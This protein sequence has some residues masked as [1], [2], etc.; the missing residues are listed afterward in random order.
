MA[1]RANWWRAAAAVFTVINVGGAIFAVMR[2][3]MMHA[4]THAALLVGTIVAWQ[5]FSSPRRQENEDSVPRLDSQVEQLQQ[6]VDAIALEVERIGE[7]QRFINKLQQE[8]ADRQPVRPRE[9]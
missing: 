7:G 3:E 8:E 5:T 2:G 6:S 9:P 1:R 4:G